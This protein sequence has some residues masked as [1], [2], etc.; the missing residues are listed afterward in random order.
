VF[1]PYEGAPAGNGH[2]WVAAALFIVF[3]VIILGALAWAIITM[4]RQKKHHA[5]LVAKSE[6]GP[7]ALHI[8]NERF[9]RGE[10]EPD[11]YKTRRD[12]LNGE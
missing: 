3:A 6:G 12:L 11:D 5:Q 4:V 9:A 2:H 1:H 7:D 10:I 8:L